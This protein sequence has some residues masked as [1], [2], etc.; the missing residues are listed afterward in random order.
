MKHAYTHI[1]YNDSFN[2]LTFIYVVRFV[3]E[4]IPFPND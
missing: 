1:F 3:Q 2:G 4:V